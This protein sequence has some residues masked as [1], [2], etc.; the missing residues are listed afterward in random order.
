VL[1]GAQDCRR[2]RTVESADPSR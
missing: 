2:I 1:T